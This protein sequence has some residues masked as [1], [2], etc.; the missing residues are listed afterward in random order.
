MIETYGAEESIARLLAFISGHTEKLKQRSVLCG[1]EGF[2]TYIIKPTKE[3]NNLGYVWGIIKKCVSEKITSG[4]RGMK[5]FKSKEGAV[6]DVQEV[7]SKE[8]E[9]ILHNDKFYGQNYTLEKATSNLPELIEPDYKGS[10]SNFANS[11]SSSNAT[12]VQLNASS[13]GKRSN[14][15]G[16]RDNR[17]DIFV[18]NLSFETTDNDLKS[19]LS[20]NEVT[21]DYDVRIATDKETGKSK[22]F[23]FVSVYYSRNFQR[24]E[25]FLSKISLS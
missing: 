18:G 12:N 21:G 13:N 24:V 16:K 10:S 6:F 22:G 3:F 1:A 23:G 17:K 7:Y 25:H 8:F 2:I 5:L 15:F 14:S 19:Y 20:K 4:I 11:S 9:E